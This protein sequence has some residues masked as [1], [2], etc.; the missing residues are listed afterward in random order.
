[1][2]IVV[3]DGY[4]LNPGDLSWEVLAEIG[5]L[6]VYDRTT[7]EQVIERSAGAEIILT[8][9]TILDATALK[10][11]PDARYIGVLATGVNVVDTES[12]R[13]LGI[14]VTNIPA[15]STDSVAQLTFA[16]ILEICFHTQKHSDSVM[17]GKWSRSADF[18]FIDYPLLELTGKTLGIIGFGNIGRKVYEIAAAFGMNVAALKRRDDP[19]QLPDLSWLTFPEL[20]GASDFVTLHCPL[21]N[22]TRGMIN[23]SSLAMMK[24]TAF[25]IN[26]SR[27]LLINEDDLAEALN[28]GTIAG[29]GLDVLSS[30]PP[31]P[32]NPL[33]NARN[34]IIT[35]HIAWATF[36]ARTRLL[37]IAIRNLKAFL[38]GSPVNRVN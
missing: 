14:V 11:L 7:S 36:E 25:L 37:E 26:T 9:K 5:D 27:G 10:S 8:N 29:A 34:I 35:P 32:D 19:P 3:L 1:M 23:K 28:Q 31:S 6:T 33:L 21:T 4:A 13:S 12:A 17:A 22:E 30:E 20:L 15:Y 18:T 16:L 38:S 2:K 24:N